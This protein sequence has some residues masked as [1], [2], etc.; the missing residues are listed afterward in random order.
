MKLVNISDKFK[1]QLST[2][3]LIVA[4][5]FEKRHSH[6]IRDIEQLI[7]HDISGGQA[8]FGQTP[9]VHPQNGQTYY[10]YEM[11]Q[12][13]FI[14]LVMGYTGQK[15]IGF[16]V[17][18]MNAFNQMRELLNSDD[19]IIQ[20]TL[21]IM[22]SRL[23]QSSLKIEQLEETTKKQESVI[24][25]LAPKAEYTD[26]VL[27]A[28]NA[29]TTTTI[30]KELDMTAN[31]L[32]KILCDLSVQHKIDDHYVLNYKHNGKALT[33]T[34]THQFINSQGEVQTSIQTVWTESGRNFI[35]KLM[36]KFSSPVKLQAGL[37]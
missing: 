16:K 19:Y 18:F 37:N 1:G 28:Q 34:R 13:A 22:K 33:T 4:E 36:S 8:L 9:Y 32:N 20:R 10:Y 14:L 27:Q 2:T 31:K 21:D 17:K 25:E 3:S 12:D 30:A 7:S 6:V 35:H 24:A 26:K 29:W 5:H 11:N 23:E 15:A